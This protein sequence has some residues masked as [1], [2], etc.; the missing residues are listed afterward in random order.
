MNKAGRLSLVNMVLSSIPT[1]HLTVFVM[2]KW[3]IKKIDKIRRNFMWKG[4]EEVHGGHCLV[5]W[6]T[7]KRLKKHG[8]LGVFDLEMFG[9]A[10]RLRWIWFE[11]VDPD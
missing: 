10:L 11:W 4:T 9:C 6:K 5:S 7:V 3:A 2:K 1:Y 8:G